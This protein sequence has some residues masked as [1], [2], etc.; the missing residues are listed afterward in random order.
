MIQIFTNI[1]IWVW[2]ILA[3]LI[4]RGVSATKDKPVYFIKSLIIPFIFILWGLDQIFTNFKF[5][6]T[7]I[8]VYLFSISVGIIFSYYIYRNRLFY[9]KD[10]TLFQTGSYIPLI[11]ILIN[12]FVKCILNISLARFPYLYNNFSFNII[13]GLLCGFT[14]G[15]FFGNILRIVQARKKQLFYNN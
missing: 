2:L 7:I 13:Y 3:F 8:I 9:V 10:D 14:V 15:L 11:I 6:S 5:H 12:F 1:P 4:R